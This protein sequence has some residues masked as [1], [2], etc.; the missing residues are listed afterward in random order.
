MKWDQYK[1]IRKLRQELSKT[2]QAM[3]QTI[4]ENMDKIE[5]R[6]DELVA[7]KLNATSIPLRSSATKEQGLPKMENFVPN[8]CCSKSNMFAPH[9]NN[10]P[11]LL[12]I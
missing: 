2:K 4:A 1:T 8:T 7:Q 3:E 9:H 5:E 11:R 12:H 6:V 10:N